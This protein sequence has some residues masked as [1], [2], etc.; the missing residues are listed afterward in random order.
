MHRIAFLSPLGGVGRTTLAAHVAALLARRGHPVVAIDLSAQNALG[1]H[2]GLP[3][4][5]AAGWLP[6][7]AQGRWWGEAALENSAG[8]GLLP[9]GQAGDA[10]A[11]TQAPLWLATQ[12]HGLDLPEGSALVL[13]TPPLPAPLAQQAARCA[14]VAVLV[15]EAS[16]R[17]LRLH[18]VLRDFAAALPSTVRWAVAVTGVDPRSEVRREALQALRQQWQER[19]IPY[20]LHADEHVQQALAQAL[21]VHQHAPAAQAAHD[22]QGV[23]DW[24]AQAC[25]L[26]AAPRA[27]EAP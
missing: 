2:L 17:S 5:P 24:L 14:D 9:Y 18:A 22:M 10:V 20:P 12:L 21:C 16:V 1:L 3:E 8:V 19:L 11:A 23:A 25:G 13:D 4:P 26:G 15:L 7:L 6:A 27:G